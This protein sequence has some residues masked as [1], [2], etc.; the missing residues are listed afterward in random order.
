MAP[1]LLVANLNSS[2]C[3]RS[4]PDCKLALERCNVHIL[5]FPCG[6]LIVGK[7]REARC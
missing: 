7:L 3:V 2:V 6:L 4:L 5:T 1:T